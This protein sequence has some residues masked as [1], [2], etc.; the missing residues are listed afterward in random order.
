MV[1]FEI[2]N[3]N[4]ITS[5]I[6]RICLKNSGCISLYEHQENEESLAEMLTF[7]TSL[8]VRRYFLLIFVEFLFF[9]FILFVITAIKRE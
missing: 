2:I 4:L 7:I 9:K 6:C 8:T 5:T 1:N 3:V